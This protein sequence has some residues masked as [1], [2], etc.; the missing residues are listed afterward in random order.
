MVKSIG[1]VVPIYEHHL[2]KLPLRTAQ[3]NIM[4]MI[5]MKKVVALLLVLVMCV[6]L[7][8][9]AF[10]SEF[11]PSISYKDHP[12]VIG[13]AIVNKNGDVIEELDW[14]QIIIIPVSKTD[15]F[16][17][18]YPAECDELEDT[19][20]K[21]K[22]GKMEIPYELVDKDIDSDSMVIRDLFY[23]LMEDENGRKDLEE[24]TSLKVTLDPD[25][26]ASTS[27]VV[28]VYYDGQWHPADVTNNGDG[29]V[30]IV[31]DHLG[32]VSFS[33][34]TGSSKPPVQT[35]DPA[36]VMLWVVLLVVSAAA[37]GGVLIL[38]RKQA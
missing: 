1:I 20:E 18:K 21:L 22:N 17:E 15:D 35:G 34:P 19:Y 38:R 28:M 23:I 10:A 25:V 36:D 26:D 33:V 24:N 5:K 16:E 12:D 2:M 6:G 4:E 8:V 30:T 37:L 29:T 3:K 9:P 31:L 7:T 32:I 11:V 14:E 27:V 13:G